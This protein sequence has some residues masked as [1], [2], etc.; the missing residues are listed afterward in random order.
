MGARSRS[1]GSGEKHQGDEEMAEGF[2][3]EVV[4]VAETKLHLL[5]GGQGEPLLILHGAGGNPGWL[6]YLTG[7]AQRFQVYVPDHPGFGTSDQPDWIASVPDLACF[8]LWALEDLG[9]SRVRIMG[10]SMGGW[11]AAEMAVM[12]PQVVERLVLVGAAGIKPTQGE[13]TDIFLLSQADMTAKMF[14]DPK[15]AP[16][17]SQLY[18]QPQTPESQD[19]RNRNREMAARITWKPYM[20]DPRLPSLLRRLRMPTLIVWGRQDA[21]VPVNCGELFQQNIRGSRL[22]IL[23]RCGHAP[24]IEQPQEFVN[25]VS[26][27]L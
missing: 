25:I 13:I 16:E 15:Q 1:T 26:E 2:I 8:Y 22:V 18:G 3:D 19:L 27:F 6:Q 17:Y 24:Q 4:E 20:H 12:C 14:Y 5:R 10:F 21:L 9:L 11:L 23:E 7:L